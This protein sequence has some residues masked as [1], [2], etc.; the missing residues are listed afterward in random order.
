MIARSA[1]V[2]PAPLRP[3]MLTI[4]PASTLSEMPWSTGAK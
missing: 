4:S 1:V 2:L 3:K